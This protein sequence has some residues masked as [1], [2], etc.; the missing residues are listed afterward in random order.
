MPECFECTTLAKKA[1]Y[2]YF[3]FPFPL[4]TAHTLLCIV[5]GDDSAVFRFFCPWWPWPLTL[6]FKLS[7]DLYTVPNHQVWSS[8]V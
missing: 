3:S 6:T 4:G 2:K 1:L 8:Y 5:I 7:R